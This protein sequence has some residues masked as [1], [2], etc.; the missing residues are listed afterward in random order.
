[1]FSAILS[2]LESLFM[3]DTETAREDMEDASRGYG[4]LLH[5]SGLK[6]N[7]A[8][9]VVSLTKQVHHSTRLILF[10]SYYYY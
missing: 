5:A 3:V 2:R 9:H 6:N 8:E 1:M 4:R 7:E 10:F